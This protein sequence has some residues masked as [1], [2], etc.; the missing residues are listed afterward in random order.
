MR[1][2]LELYSVESSTSVGVDVH[3]PQEKAAEL[4]RNTLRPRELYQVLS[5]LDTR[6]I[7]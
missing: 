5:S 2:I 4:Q 1:L 7:T 6:I 3:L